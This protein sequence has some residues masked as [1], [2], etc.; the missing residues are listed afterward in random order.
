MPSERHKPQPSKQALSN[1]WLDEF[2]VNGL[3]GLCGNN[4]QIDTRGVKSP[5]GIE[6][7][8]RFLCICPNGRAIK[9]AEDPSD[10]K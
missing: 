9:R 3:C 6:C 10:A 4:G 8:G 5:T 2:V 7:G 1:L